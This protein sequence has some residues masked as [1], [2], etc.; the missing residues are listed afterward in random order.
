MSDI[1]HGL[2]LSYTRSTYTLEKAD[3]EKQKEFVD[4]TFT[5]VKKANKRR[6]RSYSIRI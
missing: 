3:P 1:L 5:D 4:H 6:A 2:N